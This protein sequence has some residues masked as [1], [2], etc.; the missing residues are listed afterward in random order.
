MNFGIPRMVESELNINGS[1]SWGSGVAMAGHGEGLLCPPGLQ[2]EAGI[3]G[4]LSI[5]QFLTV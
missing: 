4:M 3:R 1:G 5:E 2:A